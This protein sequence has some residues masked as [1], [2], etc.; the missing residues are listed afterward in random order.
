MYYCCDPQINGW[1]NKFNAGV[2]LIMNDV[3]G[4][5]L[6]NEWMSMYT[7]ESWTFS[8]TKWTTTGPWAGIDYEQGAFNKRIIPK[9]QQYIHQYPWEI[10]QCH[11]I[12]NQNAFSF[13]FA[14]HLK[15]LYLEDYVK[16]MPEL[17]IYES[18]S[19]T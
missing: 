16:K 7:K 4:N 1:D 17:Y 12:K 18:Q 8:A 9:Y 19:H 6:I 10:F 14:M 13:H 3:I 11:T 5:Q 2:W 15:R